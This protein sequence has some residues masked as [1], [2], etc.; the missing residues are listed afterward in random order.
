MPVDR[1]S[2]YYDEA[3]ETMSP[4]A[5]RRYQAEWLH[6]LVDHAWQR[7]GCGGVSRRP[8]SPPRTS[9]ILMLSS[10]FP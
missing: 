6:D 5:R 8:G 4:S 10:G 9:R 7:P 3:R 1:K 2:G